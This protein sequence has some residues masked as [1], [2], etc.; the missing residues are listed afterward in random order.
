MRGRAGVER[1]RDRARAVLMIS[2]HRSLIGGRIGAQ[3]A[4]EGALRVLNR[5]LGM[6]EISAFIWHHLFPHIS[7]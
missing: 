7:I 2:V 6:M 5:I 3:K 1:A 4:G